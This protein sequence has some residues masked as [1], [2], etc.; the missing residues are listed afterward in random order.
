MIHDSR[1]PPEARLAR[2]GTIHERGYLAI[3]AAII[4][5]LLILVVSAALGSYSFTTRMNVVDFDN[6]QASYS[7]ARSCLDQAL[8]K[9]ADDSNY[10]GNEAFPIGDQ[11]CTVV[12]VAPSGINSIIKARAQ[13]NG[14]TTNLRLTVNTN[15]LSTVSLEEVASF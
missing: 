2:G 11:Q 15:T 10:A 14:A 8:L 5:S 13:I 7:A 12:S 1:F 4:L 3:S 6:K 9:L